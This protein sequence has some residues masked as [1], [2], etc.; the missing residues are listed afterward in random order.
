M[1]SILNTIKKLL[2][3]NVE[4]KNFDM[5]LIIHI[6]S[7]FSILDDLGVGKIE[8]YT[9]QGADNKWIEF[10]DASQ[11]E[12]YKS[13][14]YLKVRLLFDPPATSFVL[15][16]AKEQIKEFEWRIM[17]KKKGVSVI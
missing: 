4:D 15:E 14:I 8:N 5:D 3:I 17:N 1:D 2:G 16:A 6:N 12:Y 9:I 7:V 10:I 13:Y 11:I